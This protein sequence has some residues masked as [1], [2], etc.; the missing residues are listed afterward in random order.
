M[1]EKKMGARGPKA[2]LPFPHL[3]FPQLLT[4]NATTL[5]GEQGLC[6][7]RQTWSPDWHDHTIFPELPKCQRVEV[8]PENF[9]SRVLS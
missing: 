4:G 5:A 3:L 1:G 7:G 6:N 9:P 8:I 2:H